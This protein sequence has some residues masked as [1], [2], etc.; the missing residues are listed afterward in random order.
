MD[1]IWVRLYIIILYLK[2]RSFMPRKSFPHY[3]KRPLLLAKLSLELGFSDSQS[4]DALTI[5]SAL[6]CCYW[7]RDIK[8]EAEGPSPFMADWKENTQSLPFLDGSFSGS[9]GISWLH[10]IYCEHLL[11]MVSNVRIL[12]VFKPTPQFLKKFHYCLWCFYLA[13]VS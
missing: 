8:A 4:C 13:V 10:P 1:I 12:P 2:T 11:G 7:H 6:P 3:T 9:L 5:T